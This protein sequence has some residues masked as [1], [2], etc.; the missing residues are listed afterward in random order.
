MIRCLAPQ[1]SLHQAVQICRGK[2]LF[3]EGGGQGCRHELERN[4]ICDPRVAGNLKDIETD[5]EFF[6]ASPPM[7]L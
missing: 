5:I 2:D 3:Y 1:G 6:T 4:V 7:R